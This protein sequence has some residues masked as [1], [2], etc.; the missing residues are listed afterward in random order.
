VLKFIKCKIEFL[1]E[2]EVEKCISNFVEVLMD[3][4]RGYKFELQQQKK[5]EQLLNEKQKQINEI[6]T[7][8]HYQ[9]HKKGTTLLKEMEGRKKMLADLHNDRPFEKTN[10]QANKKSYSTL[11]S[12]KNTINEKL[13]TN[14]RKN[15]TSYEKNSGNTHQ[16]E[17]EQID[18]TVDRIKVI[19]E[20]WFRA[21]KDGHKN[22]YN[23]NLDFHD[24]R[25]LQT[26]Y[27]LS[28]N[29]LK[30]YVYPI[31]NQPF[32]GRID[33]LDT[34]GNNA[35]AYIGKRGYDKKNVKIHDWRSSVG[36]A[37]RSKK[38]Y[39]NGFNIVLNRTLSITDGRLINHY[40]QIVRDKFNLIDKNSITFQSL[41]KLNK[42]NK[43]ILTSL[44]D[45]QND[46][47]NLPIDKNVII[48]GVPGSGKTVIG[49][50]RLSSIAFKTTSQ[51]RY[52]FKLKYIVPN[53][54]MKKYTLDYLDQI[55]VD[56]IDFITFSDIFKFTEIVLG[57]VSD[58]TKQVLV[59]MNKIKARLTNS[60]YDS[61][62]SKCEVIYPD[63]TTEYVDKSLITKYK[64]EYSKISKDVFQSDQPNN[65]I[66]SFESFNKTQNIFSLMN[67]RNFISTILNYMKVNYNN[68]SI[69]D[70][71][72]F[73]IQ[74]D[75]SLTDIDELRYVYYF[76]RLYHKVTTEKTELFDS[77]TL[78]IFLD[79]AQ[80]YTLMEMQLL[81]S[82]FPNSNFTLCGDINQSNG[83]NYVQDDWELLRSELDASIK[84]FN[85]CFRSSQNIVKAFN[86]RMTSDKYG[87]AKA[88]TNIEGEVKTVKDLNDLN[89]IL[90]KLN[91]D[92][93]II[94]MKDETSKLLKDNYKN[95]DIRIM[96]AFDVKGLEFKNVIIFDA[97]E[98][99]K[100]G[101]GTKFY[102]MLVSRALENLYVVEL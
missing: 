17:Q 39:Q 3:Y 48:H 100:Y 25:E 5:S 93:C 64:N 71:R 73:I 89:A 10:T 96:N 23:T 55:D 19:E 63:K 36:E 84:I 102:Y 18:V 62:K 46:I 44:D 38:I 53:E 45:I 70:F 77:S 49:G 50:Y 1:A 24:Q 11:N 92:I 83:I 31:L 37:F 66:I 60:D 21:R 43:D 72:A 40:D 54:I 88:I 99:I 47:I 56:Y 4:E 2:K 97:N 90:G 91:D 61:N 82:I 57:K 94:Y 79:E 33:Y 67:N 65:R 69:K 59:G 85:V 7:R 35:V 95:K 75:F 78:S 41:L 101:N 28:I 58:T 52:D 20:R 8:S 32:I 51:N 27:N 22:F 87:E 6:K 29:H 42:E 98:I 14:N 30:N 74:N 26:T 16:Y 76:G 15:L 13:T 68:S 80:D 34:S 12:S 81:K 9:T 86:K